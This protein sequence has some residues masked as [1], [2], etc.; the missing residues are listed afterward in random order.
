MHGL[1]KNE[2]SLD[3]APTVNVVTDATTGVSR[4]KSYKKLLLS[5]FFFFCQYLG[6]FA[7]ILL[8]RQNWIRDRRI[9]MFQVIGTLRP[10]SNIHTFRYRHI[11]RNLKR[12]NSCSENRWKRI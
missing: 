7:G 2:G 9:P 5:I 11:R 8:K 1:Y 3:G 12:W 10:V 6:L 4:V